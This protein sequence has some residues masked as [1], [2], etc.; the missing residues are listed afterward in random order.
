MGMAVNEGLM[1]VVMLM[2]L[3]ERQPHTGC[4]ADGLDPEDPPDRLPIHGNGHGTTNEGSRREI[5]TRSGS[6]EVAQ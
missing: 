4:H 2:I 6:S 5:G 1:Y 3:G